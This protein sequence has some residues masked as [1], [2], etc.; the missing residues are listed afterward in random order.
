[1]E[2]NVQD[3]KYSTERR[4]RY[5]II[6]FDVAGFPL[7]PG[8]RALL[9][10]GYN[11]L[12]SLCTYSVVAASVL[13]VYMHRDDVKRISTTLRLL[14]DF[15]MLMWVEVNMRLRKNI[16]RRLFL[17]TESFTW[18]EM[19]VRDEHTGNLTIAGWIPCFNRIMK[20]GTFIGLTVHFLQSIARMLTSRDLT[21]QTWYPFNVSTSPTFEI[22]QI[23]Q[24]IATFRISALSFGLMHLYAN[25]VCIAC[26][27]L[28]KIKD[29]F[30]HIRQKDMEPEYNKGDD[31]PTD[32]DEQRMQNELKDIVRHHQEVLRYL[33]TMQDYMNSITGGILLFLMLIICTAA[34]TAVLFLF[35]RLSKDRP[36][37][38]NRHQYV[39]IHEATKPGQREGMTASL[40][41]S[42]TGSLAISVFR[43]SPD[44]WTTMTSRCSE[45]GTKLLERSMAVMTALQVVCAT[46]N[47][48][49]TTDMTQSL[50]V[51][52]SAMCVAFVYCGFGTLLS[53]M[54]DSV[55]HA[56]WNSDWVGTPVTYQ[57]SISFIIMISSKGFELKAWKVV[58]VSNSTFMSRTRG[59]S[60]QLFHI[61]GEYRRRK[62]CKKMALS[63]QQHT[64]PGIKVGVHPQ[65]MLLRKWLD[66]EVIMYYEL[67]PRNVTITAYIYCQ[68]LRYLA[69]V[70]EEKRLRT[71]YQA[72]LQHDNERP[73]SANMTKAVIQELGRKMIPQSLYSPD[74]R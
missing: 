10:R 23:T 38:H 57:K 27:Q 1:M 47:L 22:I 71:L 7:I 31:I 6:F 26:T 66:K 4:F 18:E 39:I 45:I 21:F 49:D 59:R 34:F 73:H 43:I 19:A 20:R 44:R 3:G 2:S 60:K 37:P 25:L 24:V 9:Q 69:D 61:R 74:F 14:L 58:P 13:D 64:T 16:L 35:S 12:V 30:L 42:K 46:L 65:K 17:L 8:K 53:D 15:L 5:F 55:R 72:L 52:V 56:A 33:R 70:I 28:H 32:G 62:H 50:L 48:G 11:S 68:K 40:R 29:A 67:L 36:K 51:Y 54:F 63:F 41:R